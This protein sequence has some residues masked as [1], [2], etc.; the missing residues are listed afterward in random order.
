MAAPVILAPE[1]QLKLRNILFATDFSEGSKLA[2]PYAGSLA[3][4]F[5]SKVHLCHIEAPVP[6]SSGVAAPSLYEALGKETA[7]HLTE[8]L[9]APA[10][11]G[12]ELKFALGEGPVRDEISRIVRD[13]NID[14]IVAGTHGHTGLKH[15]LLG[16]VVE[17]ICR[18]AR[19]PV[20]TVGPGTPFRKNAPFTRILVPTNLNEGSDKI[21]PYVILLASEFGAQVVALHIIPKDD[22]EY[23]TAQDSNL[24]SS[25]QHA[26]ENKL[27]PM[28]AFFR[29]IFLVASGDPAE[30]ILRTAALQKVDLIA[31]GIKNVMPPGFQIRSSTAYRIIAGAQCPV[32][33]LK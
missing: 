10:M 20:L 2:L 13:Q 9:N 22:V 23:V 11:K 15:M 14:L 5:G 26:M 24:A 31:M 6:L 32:L 28:L 16:S 4:A 29:P 25:I 18:S 12:V 3:R 8:L 19:C 21:M 33:T 17:E 7:D 27:R 1:T 30:T